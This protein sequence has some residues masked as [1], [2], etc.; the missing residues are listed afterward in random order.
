MSRRLRALVAIVLMLGSLA[1][2]PGTAHSTPTGVAHLISPEV[3]TRIPLRDSHNV[4]S[5]DWLRSP[6]TLAVGVPAASVSKDTTPA[7]FAARPVPRALAPTATGSPNP[8]T[9]PPGS[10]NAPPSGPLVTSTGEADLTGPRAYARTLVNAIQWSCL[11]QLWQHESGWR[12]NAANDDSTAF[13]IAQRLDETS[14]SW[15]VQIDNGIAYIKARY[16]TAC[17]AWAFWTRNRWY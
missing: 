16:R 8:T 14:K 11:S 15:R 13:G 1:I 4:A 10:V 2:T 12:T 9:L 17:A 3:V 7:R 5:R 6:L